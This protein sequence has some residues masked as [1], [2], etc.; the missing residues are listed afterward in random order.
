MSVQRPK[1]DEFAPFY[2]GY[3]ARVADVADAPGR[4]RDQG[5]A[6][7][8]LLGS[9][10]EV[11]SVFRYAPE[12]WSIKEVLG[13]LADAERVFAYR[14]LRVARGDETPMPGFDEQAW[15]REAGFDRSSLEDL[16][17]SF[18]A[19]RA[20]TSALVRGVDPGAWHRRGV[21]NGHPVTARSLLYIV[22]GHVEHHLE[23]LKTRYGVGTAG[24]PSR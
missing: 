24:A 7:G 18:Q 3:I 6:V 8:A 15:V 4:L 10:S 13:H 20:A 11:A 12:K 23:V 14:L 2:A 17:D 21:A 16:S 19:A 5:E 9:V 1:P 22:L